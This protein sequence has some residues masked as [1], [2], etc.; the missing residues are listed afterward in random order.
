[1][2]RL[3]VQQQQDQKKMGAG[4]QGPGRAPLRPPP[5]AVAAIGTFFDFGQPMQLP[6][7]ALESWTGEQSSLLGPIM[8]LPD[9]TMWN[10]DGACSTFTGQLHGTAIYL[11]SPPFREWTAVMI[12]ASCCGGAHN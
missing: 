11:A 6:L 12:I 4:M 1:M 10:V 2:K 9:I 3:P 7:G 5:Q 8:L